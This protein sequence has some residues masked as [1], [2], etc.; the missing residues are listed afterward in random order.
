MVAAEQTEQTE[1]TERK[2]PADRPVRLLT[3]VIGASLLVLVSGLILGRTLLADWRWVHEPMHAA[4]EMAGAVVALLVAY[5]L[6]SVH[7]RGG[8]GSYPVW[9]AAALTGMGVL[10]GI[11]AMTHAGN[12]FVWLHSMA[13]FAGAALFACVWLPARWMERAASWWPTAV[14]AAALS[15]GVG[16]LIF[17]GVQPLMNRG[18]DFTAAADALNIGGGVLMFLAALRLG[19]TYRHT[20]NFDDLLFC[21]HCTLFGAAAVMFVQS[22][23]WDLAWWA[24]HLLR[25]TAYGMA[26]WFVVRSDR[27][28]RFAQAQATRELTR[29]N[30]ELEQRVRARTAELHTS[31]ELTR[32]II[33]T[34]HEAFVAIDTESRIVDWNAQAEATFGWPR[35]EA[36]GRHLV[37]TVI[38]PQYRAAHLG[39]IERFLRTGEGPALGRR[40]ELTALHRDGHEFP[41]ELTIGAVPRNGEWLF[42]AFVHDI[43][44]RKQAEAELYQAKEVA[45]AAD[46][47]KSEFLA[48]MSHEIRTPMNAVIGLTEL[49]LDTDLTEVQREYLGMAQGSAESLL[50]LIGDILDFSKIEAGRMELDHV[51]FPLRETLGDTM[52]ALALRARDKDPKIELA[53][54]IRPNVPD[55]LMGDPHRLR[56]VVTNLVGNAIKFTE[57]GEVVL[58]VD[59]AGGADGREAPHSNGRTRIRVAVRD[60]GIGIPPEKQG[61]IFEAFTQADASTTRRFGGTGLGL[62]I[63]ARLVQLMG[64][65]LRVESEPGRGSTFHFTA[66][67]QTAAECRAT[68]PMPPESLA[69]MRVLVVDD[70]ATNR[71]ILTETL[72]N[73]QMRP[74]AVAG[75]AEAI[76]ALRRA[77]ETGTPFQLILTDVHMPRMDGFELMQAVQSV[78]AAAGDHNPV[79]LM[80]SSG[81]GPADVARCRRLGGAG[82]LIKPIKQSELFDVVVSAL[83]TIDHEP[84][85]DRRE[86]AAGVSES[87]ER[88]EPPALRPLRIL[89][90]EDSYPNQRLAVGVL[91]NWGH[92][93]TVAENGREAVAAVADAAA[94]PF[95][96]VLMDV[97]MPEMDGYQATAVIREREARGGGRVPIIAMTAHAMKGDREECLAAGMDGYV[98]KPIRRHELQ[99]AMIEVLGSDFVQHTPPTVQPAGQPSASSDLDWDQ[100]LESVEGD[101][102]LLRVVLAAI[103]SECRRRLDETER[104][105][106]E[107]DAETLRRAAH[108]IHGSLRIFGRTRAAA[109]A[110]Q[111]EAVGKSGQC[112]GA[113][114]LLPALR[115]EIDL[116]LNE[117]GEY[118][119]KNAAIP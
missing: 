65:E 90:A 69:G 48:N 4:A 13:T 117:V 83:G 2:R 82:Y 87:S 57:R 51:P 58:E 64:G 107:S 42:C 71:L 86:D 99:S 19:L 75:G 116:I 23:L 81:D 112:D 49:V 100:A 79:I 77:E 47:A 34:A 88:P 101:E 56:Q 53:C 31:A 22:A 104:A 17:P 80:L 108:T 28:A 45:E 111:I 37:E 35:Q 119:A 103:Q 60:T 30:A 62:T 98:S 74:T 72:T 1:Q 9:I 39:G 5:M 76:E 24:W 27:E 55:R 41:V 106:R 36:L 85:P 84:Q 26:L 59:V 118:L 11:H 114:E 94:E 113:H 18:P 3:L 92:S 29:L 105:V 20:R 93:V 8:G 96:L 61:A 91:T 95:D 68:T 32:S 16:S 38:P 25:L 10:D 6:L 66:P 7:Q 89:L 14:L 109:V 63:T 97:Q 43:T 110:E 54:R 40:L 21:L 115:M 15:F 50:A 44:A 73:W 46:R 33:E 102:E 12:A 67:F 52:K 78:G 70:N